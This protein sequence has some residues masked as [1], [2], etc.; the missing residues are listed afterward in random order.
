MFDHFCNLC[1]FVVV[2]LFIPQNV[3]GLITQPRCT[4]NVPTN[5]TPT[6]IA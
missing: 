2:C 5:I 1:M 3:Y 6:N 4:L